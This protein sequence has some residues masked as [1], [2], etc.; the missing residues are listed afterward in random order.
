MTSFLKPSIFSFEK[1][2]RK[3]PSKKFRFLQD[4]Q[5]STLIR[6]NMKDLQPKRIPKPSEK[7]LKYFSLSVT[8]K[9]NYSL[10]EITENTFENTEKKDLDRS[11]LIDDFYTRKK[12]LNKI[13]KLPK[14][15]SIEK[16]PE[17]INSTLQENKVRTI[18]YSEKR[19]SRCIP[20]AMKTFLKVPNK[21]EKVSVPN[22]SA[23]KPVTPRQVQDHSHNTNEKKRKKVFPAITKVKNVKMYN[24]C[25]GIQTDDY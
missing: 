2:N 16:I 17:E 10:C 19:T 5:E 20:Q 4:S 15:V 24:N 25:M 21:T 18:Y 1:E 3:E 6:L 22:I 7:L 13:Q 11:K 14:N 12:T 8:A 23:S 9:L